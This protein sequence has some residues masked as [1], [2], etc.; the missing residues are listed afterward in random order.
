MQFP[1][2]DPDG[3]LDFPYNTSPYQGSGAVTK[4]APSVRVNDVLLIKPGTGTVAYGNYIQCLVTAVD[5]TAGA[6]G[7]FTAVPTIVGGIIPSIPVADEIIIIGNAHGEGS[8]QPKALSTTATKYENQIQTFKELRKV[9]GTEACM[10]HWF[11]DRNGS[12]WFT[13]KGETETLN[14]S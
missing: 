2:H 6:N 1:S 9:T 10:K 8:N 13:M 7:E 11:Q 5:P 12:H 4:K 14:R 3:I